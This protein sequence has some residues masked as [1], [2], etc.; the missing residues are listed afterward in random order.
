ML[1]GLRYGPMHIWLDNHKLPFKISF[2]FLFTGILFCDIPQCLLD[3]VVDSL[4]GE[5]E[6][7][8]FI[9]KY[10]VDFRNGIEIYSIRNGEALVAKLNTGTPELEL[11]GFLYVLNQNQ[12]TQREVKTGIC[13]AICNELCRQLHTGNY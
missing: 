1:F 6:V 12:M 4:R 10:L 2:P 13:K 9:A 5:P 3:I 11:A 7:C 8:Q